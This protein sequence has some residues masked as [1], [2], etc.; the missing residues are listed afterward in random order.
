MSSHIDDL[1]DLFPHVPR[2]ELVQRLESCTDVNELLED[3]LAEYALSSQNGPEHPVSVHDQLQD[4]FPDVSSEIIAETLKRN[5]NDIQLCAYELLSA[6][7][8][9]LADFCGLSQSETK[10]VL[11]K[12]RGDSVCALVE[13][14]A[15]FKRQKKVWASRV[16]G[17][18]TTAANDVMYVY[19][20]SSAEARELNGFVAQNKPLQRLNYAFLKRLLV[21]FQGDVFKVLETGKRVVDAHKELFTFDSLLKLLPEP[22]KAINPSAAEVL[23][24]GPSREIAQFSLVTPRRNSGSKLQISGRN[25]AAAA[26]AVLKIDLHGYLVKDAVELAEKTVDDWWNAEL[27]YR[28]TEGYIEKYGYKCQFVEPLDVVTGRGIHSAGGPKIRG[29]VMK[30]L[31]RKGYQYEEVCGRLLVLGRK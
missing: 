16:Q 8:V 15:T 18:P 6:P 11:Q 20:E 13:I 21:F 10:A 12:H 2:S 27:Y 4:F 26:R 3:L 7:N 5:N 28:E 22:F 17:R 14:V 30:M 24:T 23:R 1:V 25:V 29:A 31:T 9:E 19:N